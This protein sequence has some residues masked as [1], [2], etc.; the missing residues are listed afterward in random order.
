MFVKV[1]VFPKAKKREI[2][3]H[4]NNKLEVWVKAEPKLGQ[5]NRETFQL[6][7]DFFQIPENQVKL[8]RG[9]KKRNKIFEIPE[10]PCLTKLGRLL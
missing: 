3:S 10:T 7:A 5:A 2:K 9:A 1:K 8:I 6:I 4:T